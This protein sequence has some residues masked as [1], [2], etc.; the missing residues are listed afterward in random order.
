MTRR[1]PRMPELI[2]QVTVMLQTST[3]EAGFEVLCL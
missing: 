2:K 3:E 1:G